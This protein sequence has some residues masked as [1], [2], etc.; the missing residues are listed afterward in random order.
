MKLDLKTVPDFSKKSK[1]KFPSNE[2]FLPDI[3]NKLNYFKSYREGLVEWFNNNKQ[4]A[5]YELA[6]HGSNPLL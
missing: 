2:E 3:K 4:R 5:K 6:E 1:E